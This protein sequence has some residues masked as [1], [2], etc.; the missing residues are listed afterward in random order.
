[1][2]FF[3]TIFL[4][5][6]FY[7]IY[8][9][10]I[11]FFNRDGERELISFLFWNLFYELFP[12]FHAYRYVKDTERWLLGSSCLNVMISLLKKY[13]PWRDVVIYDNGNEKEKRLFFIFIFIFSIQKF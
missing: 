12:G 10:F 3:F 7:F 1:M 6:S 11:Y 4:F 9:L 5:F 13:D 8:Y 2:I